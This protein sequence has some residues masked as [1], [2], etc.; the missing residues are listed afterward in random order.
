VV[1]AL[2]KCPMPNLHQLIAIIRR[3]GDVY[4]A[5]C[6]ELDVVSQG[7]TLEEARAN[8][9]EAAELFLELALPTEIVLPAHGAVYVTPIEL[10]VG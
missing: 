4:V 1:R 10:S 3:E 5:L 7:A 2:V 6:P 8:V 9:I